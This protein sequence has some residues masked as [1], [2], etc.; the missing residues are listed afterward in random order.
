MGTVLQLSLG[1]VYAWLKDHCGPEAST[2]SFALGAG[3]LTVGL[4]ASLFLA[5]SRSGGERQVSG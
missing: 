5:A 4:M 1:S 3:L 2:Y